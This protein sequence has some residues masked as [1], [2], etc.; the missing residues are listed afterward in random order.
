MFLHENLTI[1]FTAHI[2]KI[3]K[4]GPEMHFIS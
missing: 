4:E 3:D 2:F 1:S